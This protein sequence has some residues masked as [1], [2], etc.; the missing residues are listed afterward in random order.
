[1]SVEKEFTF[2]GNPQCV[3]HVDECLTSLTEVR[4]SHT[5]RKV[6]RAVFVKIEDLVECVQ[7]DRIADTWLLKAEKTRSQA[8]ENK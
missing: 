8:R 4:P 7:V 1:M 6:L 5:P 3:V 2:E